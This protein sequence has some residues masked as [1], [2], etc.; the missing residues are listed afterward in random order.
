MKARENS[1]GDY[2]TTREADWRAFDALPA[3]LR[4]AVN[5]AAQP[6]ACEPILQAWQRGETVNDLIAALRR[7]DLTFTAQTYGPTHP[8]AM[9]A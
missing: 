9:R 5:V 1:Y 7:T 3:R 6:Y 4:W 8:E 2:R